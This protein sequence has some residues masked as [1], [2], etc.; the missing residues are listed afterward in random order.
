MMEGIATLDLSAELAGHA[1]AEVEASYSV[2]GEVDFNAKTGEADA[3]VSAGKLT[4]KE[5]IQYE[6]SF[7]GSISLKA[8]PV[9]TVLPL[10]GVPVTFEPYARAEIK[11][12]A[13]AS[14]SHSNSNRPQCNEK[15]KGRKAMGYRGC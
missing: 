2:S 8:G 5:T 11:A 13:H 3:T 10:P 14:G 7:K 4:H 15:L 12:Y 1:S 6:S 9:F